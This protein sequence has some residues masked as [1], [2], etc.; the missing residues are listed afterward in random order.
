M[1]KSAF[2]RWTPKGDETV[3]LATLKAALEAYREKLAKTGEQLGW[4]YAHYA[5]PYRIEEK[6]K[7]GLPYLE[8]VGHDPVMYRRLLMTAQTVDGIGV[9]QITLPDDATQGD[10]NKAN[11]LARYLAKHYQAELLLFNGRVQYF[12]VGKK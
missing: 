8:L 1:P 7:D 4:D 10:S 6:E 2:V 11:E 12:T 3:D 9:V 5:F